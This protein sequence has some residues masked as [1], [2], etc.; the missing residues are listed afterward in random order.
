MNEKKT[1]GRPRQTEEQRREKLA[2]KQAVMVQT[3]AHK[4]FLECMPGGVY[5]EGNPEHR[6]GHYVGIQ[7]LHSSHTESGEDS[8][9]IL[10]EVMEGLDGV[11]LRK[12]RYTMSSHGRQV[13][14]PQMTI[15]WDQVEGV[16]R[17]M[18]GIF[19]GEKGVEIK[20]EVLASDKVVVEEKAK[21][22]AE[23]VRVACDDLSWTD[24]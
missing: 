19:G 23:A 12:P 3:P 16:A 6:C 4:F 21:A 17:A 11:L 10:F 22:E 15:E 5:V 2:A 7:K 24:V 1:V 18:L 14:Y 9:V 20:K 13:V 8:A